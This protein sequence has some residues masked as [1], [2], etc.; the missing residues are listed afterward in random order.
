[1]DTN[2]NTTNIDT[3]YICLF[4]KTIIHN[5]N[6]SLQR[7]QQREHL[8]GYLNSISEM[9]P[10]STIVDQ[11]RHS[12]TAGKHLY[13]GPQNPLLR[14]PT[15]GGFS[16]FVSRCFPAVKYCRADDIAYWRHF[17]LRISISKEMSPTT[18]KSRFPD[19]CKEVGRHLIFIYFD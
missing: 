3:K 5:E 19:K 9:K 1:M 11:V 6:I 12:W 17:W 2:M 14:R 8:L 7:E 18:W 15:S 4:K 10:I 16:W 13:W